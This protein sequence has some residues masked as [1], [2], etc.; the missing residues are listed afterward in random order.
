MN[1][2]L[3]QI[4]TAMAIVVGMA[5]ASAEGDMKRM[6]KNGQSFEELSSCTIRL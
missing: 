4:V 6:T 3:L 2:R 1:I 5:A